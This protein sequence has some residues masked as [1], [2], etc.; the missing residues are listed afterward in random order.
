MRQ[1]TDVEVRE[2]FA[3][4]RVMEATA[5]RLEAIARGHHQTAMR[6]ALQ[7]DLLLAAAVAFFIVRAALYLSH[8]AF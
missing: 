6:Y 7:R 2:F 4:Y 5:R 1:L 3:A 8:Q